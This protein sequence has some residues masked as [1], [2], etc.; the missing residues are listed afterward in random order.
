MEHRLGRTD[1]RI[2]DPLEHAQD[3]SKDSRDNVK[4]RGDEVAD[5]VGHLG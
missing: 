1:D 5:G 2:K 4:E 3:G